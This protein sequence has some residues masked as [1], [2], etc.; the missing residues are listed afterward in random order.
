ME[1]RR[2]LK[3]GAGL[4]ALGAS[5]AGAG[6]WAI[7]P[8]RR[9][10]PAANLDR[11]LRPKGRPRVGVVGGGL[12]GLSTAIT[13]GKRGFD[14]HLFE[15]APHLGGKLGGWEVEALG[16]RLPVEHGFHGFFTQYYNL[17]QLLDEAG[18]GPDLVPAPSYPILYG[19]RPAEYFVP[20]SAPFPFNLMSV[21]SGSRSLSSS[22]F[23]GK[24]PGLLEMMA[25]EEKRTF[26]H[27]DDMSFA[28]FLR[29]AGVPEVMVEAVLAPFGN[30]T[31]NSLERLSAAEGIR[32]FHAYFFG[33]PEPLAFRILARD[34]MT[35]VVDRLE[36]LATR[37][38][39]SIHAGR[40]VRR[41]TTDG[42]RVSEVELEPSPAAVQLQLS[43]HERRVDADALGPE[44]K[45]HPSSS[46][47]PIFVRSKAGVP[48]ALVGRCTHMGCPVAREDRGF[49]CP[50]HGGR[51]D[52]EGAVVRGPPRVP[53]PRLKMQ[54]EGEGFRLVDEVITAEVQRVPVDYAVVAC[55]GVAT[56]QLIER[57]RLGAGTAW[58]E[59]V[60]QLEPAD[61]YAVWRVWLDRP[62]RPERAPF[63][64]VHQYRYTDSLAIYSDFQEPY[65][66]WANA[67]GASVVETHAY[68]I[69]PSESYAD[70]RAG[71][72]RELT[73]LLPELAGA[74]VLHEE[75]QM[76]RNFT[77]FPPGFA[78]H[79]PATRTTLPNLFLAGDWVRLPIP[80]FLMEAAVTSGKLAAHAV[81]ENERLQ[82]E[83]I[84]H[85]DPEGPLAR[86]V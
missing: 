71:L 59:G 14:V 80:A 63:S 38:G 35:A 53:L 24:F 10:L 47:H 30:A 39:V 27:R 52:D 34:V 85:V 28:D 4:G 21:I 18:A 64:T 12:A 49:V 29:S 36:A 44:W 25:Y 76:Q 2:F 1:R 26:F 15:S 70:V 73:M 82:T 33:N 55:D 62:T 40:P 48:E 86:W 42:Q 11:P 16:E 66:S 69:H 6:V 37:S 13:L 65:I 60:R 3:L 20:S 56:R 58:G 19:D 22:D 67:R 75:M 7:Q 46:P 54:L 51:F 79:R 23:L 43:A 45:L 81:L 50:C 32:F 61:P 84:P 57:S 5:G 17:W 31:M 41:L 83:P 72:L 9:S 68:A 74:R 78:S 77:S 8:R